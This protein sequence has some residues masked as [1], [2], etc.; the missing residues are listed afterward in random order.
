V[1]FFGEGIEGRPPHHVAVLGLSRTFQ[2]IRPRKVFATMPVGE[3]LLLGAHVQLARGREQL[4]LERLEATL[5]RVYRHV[6]FY[7][8]KLD[9]LGLD[10]DELRSLD[11]LGKPP[12]TVKADLRASHPYGGEGKARRVVDR[13]KLD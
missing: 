2:H 11:D 12:F 1:R 4:Q 5:S 10:P 9:G 6:P 7:R 3:N 13:R 8:K